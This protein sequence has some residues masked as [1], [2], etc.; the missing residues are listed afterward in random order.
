MCGKGGLG[1]FGVDGEGGGYGMG[2]VG[3][4]LGG[5]L[6]FVVKVGSMLKM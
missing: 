5:I 6:L 1:S 2:L 3:C 4:G